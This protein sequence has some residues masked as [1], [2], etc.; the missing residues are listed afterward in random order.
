MPY[1]PTLIEY[2]S[3]LRAPGGGRICRPGRINIEFDLPAGMRVELTL[4]P[5]FNAY[6]CIK[7]GMSY[8]VPPRVL[9]LETVQGGSM[10]IQGTINED[11]MRETLGYYIIY[12]NAD[13]ITAYVTNN[14]MAL[15]RIR[16]TQWNL[17]I[18]TEA[19]F[20]ILSHCLYEYQKETSTGLLRELINSFE[21]MSGVAP[22]AGIT[23]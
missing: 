9:F 17:I 6:A 22:R 21:K 13:P 2:L 1:L 4:L 7:Y 19:D 20:N 16:A 10:Y 23:R 5:P 14:S 12:T 15:Q 8:D 18:N 11:V 3:A